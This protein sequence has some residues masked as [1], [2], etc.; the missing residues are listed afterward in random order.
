[1]RST[2]EADRAETSRRDRSQREPRLGSQPLRL[3][4]AGAAGL[5]TLL[6]DPYQAPTVLRPLLGGPTRAPTV[7]RSLLG[8][9]C[10]PDGA[11]Q[12]TN[13]ERVDL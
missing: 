13:L 4:Y 11:D 10:P 2:C 5:T 1:M 12:L 3:A 8:D 6:S 9:V 7:S